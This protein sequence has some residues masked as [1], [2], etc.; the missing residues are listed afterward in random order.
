MNEITI[1]RTTL[2]KLLWSK[3]ISE[4]AKE[5]NTDHQTLVGI[6][7]DYNIPRPQSGHW[8]KVRLG[9]VVAT[10]DLPESEQSD[11]NITL[12]GKKLVTQL[13][14]KTDVIRVKQKIGI[15]HN[16][17]QRT[18]D[19]LKNKRTSQHHRI[20]SIG[21][22]ILDISVTSKHLNRAIRIIDTIVTEFE[23]NG[24]EV[25]TTSYNDLSKSFVVIDGEEIYFHIHEKGK[26]IKNPD[27]KYSWDE[28]QH[29]N[30]GELILGLSDSKY[31][32]RTRSIADG[33]TQKLEDKMEKF[34]ITAFDMA[35]KLKEERIKFE[36]LQNEANR[37]REEKERLQQLKLEIKRQR[38]D[39]LKKEI[40]R[41]SELEN[42]ATNL[43]KSDQIMALIESVDIEIRKQKLNDVQKRKYQ[44]W[45]IFAKDYAESINPILDISLALNIIK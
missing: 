34:F 28:F 22:S 8:T 33:K 29:I 37:V 7:N 19:T 10:P 16:L 43:F 35:N 21:S 13:P 39:R 40:S 14:K 41:R 12:S 18:F 26:R 31:W 3:P 36:K 23:K 30:T 24:F 2:F 4:I 25:K 32:S 15:L 6:C 38:E 5:Y 20:R 17:T 42:Q 11:S 44:D 1:T 27:Q 9:K 45:R